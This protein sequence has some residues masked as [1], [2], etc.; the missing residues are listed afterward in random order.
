MA[1]KLLAT[2]SN[3]AGVG[4]QYLGFNG[5]KIGDLV[6]DATYSSNIK[7]S[8]TVTEHPVERSGSFATGS[9][10][11][12]HIYNNS[13]T[14][15]LQ[16]AILDSPVGILATARSVLDIFSGDILENISNKYK[17]KGKNQIAAYEILTDM[18]K[19]R[20][21]FTLVGYNDVID[22]L[23]IE[24]L[25]FPRD[26]DTG[27]R[28]FFNIKLKQLRFAQSITVTVPQI[29]TAVGDLIDSRLNL[30][31]QVTKT[32]TATDARAFESTLSKFT[33]AVIKATKSF[34]GG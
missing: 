12:D 27:N 23:V 13:T 11:S 30:G 14:I 20:I 4:K 8:N 24:S 18:Q 5:T 9:Y 1:V 7:Y 19:E 16:C 15:D 3:L 34:F 32:P 25:E 6:I 21:I 17:G 22:N 2:I 26:G 33:G 31:G 29:S 28:L 10:V